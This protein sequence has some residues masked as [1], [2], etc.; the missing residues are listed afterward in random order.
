MWMAHQLATSRAYGTA[1]VPLLG[2][3]NTA[4]CRSSSADSA[5]FTFPLTANTDNISTNALRSTILE[6]IAP[7]WRAMQKGV[8]DLDVREVLKWC[9]GIWEPTDTDEE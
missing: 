4:T 2:T 1:P 8:V 7:C 6:T 3:S 9:V 5:T